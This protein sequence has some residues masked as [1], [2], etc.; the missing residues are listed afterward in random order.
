MG[1]NPVVFTEEVGPDGMTL[2]ERGNLWA[3]STD[4]SAHGVKVFSPDGS[5]I[6]SL[7]F[8]E[9]VTNLQFRKDVLYFTGSKNLYSLK[10][11]VNGADPVYRQEAPA[12]KPSPAP[13]PPAPPTQPP[14]CPSWCPTNPQPWSMKCNWRACGECGDCS[15]PPA[16]APTPSPLAPN[17]PSPSPLPRP[18]ASLCTTAKPNNAVWTESRCQERCGDA[19][20]CK[21]GACARMCTGCPC[22]ASR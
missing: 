5:C 15:A 9:K 22:G 4:P 13:A 17:P 18:P 16:A 10:L 12:P 11:Q 19:N 20:N 8:P 14:G 1:T 2:D 3:T 6:L 7:P 21:S